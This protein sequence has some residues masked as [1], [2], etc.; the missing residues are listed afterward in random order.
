MMKMTLS[1]TRSRQGHQFSEHGAVVFVLLYYFISKGQVDTSMSKL[2]VFLQ[3][4]ECQYLKGYFYEG[5]KV[6]V[7]GSKLKIYYYGMDIWKSE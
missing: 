4:R 3:T 1:K 6:T 5:Q 7:S 2:T